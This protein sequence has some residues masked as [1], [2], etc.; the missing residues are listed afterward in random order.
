MKF[1]RTLLGLALAATALACTQG[2]IAQ[3]AYKAEYKMSLVL[4]PPT[5]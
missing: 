3:G 5:P 2:A 4:G 1:R